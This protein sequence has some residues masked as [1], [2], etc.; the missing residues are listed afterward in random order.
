MPKQRGEGIIS[1]YLR[2]MG[3][4]G[5]RNAI[6]RRDVAKGVGL[7]CARSVS[8]V[9]ETERQTTV[10][11]SCDAGL[12]LPTDDAEGDLDVRNYI[13]NVSRKAAGAFRSLTAARHYMKEVRGQQEITEVTRE[14]GN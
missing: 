4:I 12:F 1:G 2:R 13:H 9:L 6:K 5:R 10:I 11:C 14:D 3:A 8:R 7:S